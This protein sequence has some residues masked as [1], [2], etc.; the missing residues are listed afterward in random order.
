M[1]NSK[2]NRINAIIEKIR[3]ISEEFDE[4][5]EEL[6][7]ICDEEEECYDNMISGG[8]GNLQYTDNAEQMRVAIKNI[9]NA[10]DLL[11]E[12]SDNLIPSLEEATGN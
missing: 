9:G 2:R 7:E 5:K 10:I 4:L 1:N 12:V 6:Q 3:D 11:N 8:N